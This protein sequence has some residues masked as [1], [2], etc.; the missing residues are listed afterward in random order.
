MEIIIWLGCSSIQCY[1]FIDFFPGFYRDYKLIFMWQLK[2]VSYFN[3]Y[4]NSVS[5]LFRFLTTPY[6]FQ[7]FSHRLFL[8]HLLFYTQILVWTK[9][10]M[11]NNLNCVKSVQIWIF[12]WSVFSRTQTEYGDLRS[13]FLYSV[14]IRENPDQKKLRTW[15]LFTQC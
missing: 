15:T 13:E 1:N 12:F 5:Y 3:I 11:L 6:Q 10:I 4:Q 8:L 7:N 9:F 14:R 2:I